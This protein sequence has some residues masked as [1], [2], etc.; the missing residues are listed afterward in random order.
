M[1]YRPVFLPV[2]KGSRLVEEVPINFTWHSGMAPSQKKKNVAEL[3]K[4]AALDGLKPLLEVSSKSDQE[5]GKRLSAFS[6]RIRVDDTK[7]ATLESAYQSSK[8]FEFGGPYLDLIFEDS[9]T[10]KRDPRLRESGKLL[11]F[12]FKGREY[13]LTPATGFYDWLYLNA[14][15]PHRIWLKRIQKCI[16]F[17]DIE[18]NPERSLNCQARSLATFV[19]L[20]VR[21]ELEEAVSSFDRFSDILKSS[22]V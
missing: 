16:G 5:V 20:D 11:R 22:S 9:R 19:A 13:P 2:L 7:E 10:S 18:F 21:G 14:L 15:F 4:A 3:H 6:L 8:V 1:A 17:T 12:R